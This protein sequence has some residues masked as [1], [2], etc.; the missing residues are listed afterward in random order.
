VNSGN[1]SSADIIHLSGVRPLSEG[2]FHED[3]RHNSI[4]STL[5]SQQ[6]GHLQQLEDVSSISTSAPPLPVEV[7]VSTAFFPS[8][9][10]FLNERALKQHRTSVGNISTIS[11]DIARRGAVHHDI[12]DKTKFNELWDM[13]PM[14]ATAE[15]SESRRI[16]M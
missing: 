5:D 9:F 7:S 3:E 16:R 12:V 14:P 15:V 2:P 6:Y 8:G 13:G 11:Q 10:F 4:P 1:G